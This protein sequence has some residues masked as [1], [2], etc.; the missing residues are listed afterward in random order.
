M[1]VGLAQRANA[2]RKT[3]ALASWL[4]GVA[5]RIAMKAKRDAA[6][7]RAHEREVKAVP[8]TPRK[9]FPDRAWPGVQVVLYEEIQRLP[10]KYRVV[11]LLC[12]LEGKNSTEVAKEFSL[13]EATC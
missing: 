13:Q 8:T 12:C 10:E 1:F 11:V 3:E 7:R 5:Y 4:H 6:R 9:S 2:I